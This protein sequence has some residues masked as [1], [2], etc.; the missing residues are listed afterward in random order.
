MQTNVSLRSFNTFGVDA[1]GKF[2]AVISSEAE[3]SS[4]FKSDEFISLRLNPENIL[5]LGGGSNL[6]FTKD[7]EG[8]IVK[9]EISGM[10]VV[11]QKD[12]MVLVEVGGGVMW[13]DFVMHCIN[14]GWGGVENLSLIPGTVGAAPVQNIGAYGVELKDVFVSLRGWDLKQQCFRE[15]SNAE[16]A[17]G[18]RTS[19]F[20]TD[21]KN[22]LLITSVVFKLTTTDH[23]L[24]LEYGA[25]REHLNRYSIVNPT[26][27]DI[28]DAVIHIRRSKLPDPG[29]IGN[30]GS[31][32]KNPVIS[33]VQLDAI[34]I[35]YPEVVAHQSGNGYKIAAGWLIE[36]AG[37]KGYKEGHVGCHDKQ[38][39]V[40]VNY[41]GA[42]GS[43]IVELSKKIQ[44]SVVEQFGVQLEPEVN[45]L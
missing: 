12:D 15:F 13:H 19:I 9:N 10:R 25:I 11:E 45:I 37:W 39:L 22:R 42:T 35:K 26:I 44:A 31:F 36:K 14:N 41:G 3:A 2:V 33:K 28:S 40:L 6:L 20:K 30:A 27:K 7:F 5:L 32:F 17:F 38:A 24:S 4:F 43:E 34:S 23:H 18:Y 29:E 21:Y 16:C 1:M 8:L